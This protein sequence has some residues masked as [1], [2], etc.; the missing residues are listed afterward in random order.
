MAI[1]KIHGFERDQSTFS[2]QGVQLKVS[3]TILI[4]ATTPLITMAEVINALPNTISGPGGTTFN[5]LQLTFT[6]FQSRHP[7]S[8]LYYLENVQSLK[9]TGDKGHFWHLRLSYSTPAA[10]GSPGSSGSSSATRSKK[11]QRVKKPDSPNKDLQEPITDPTQRPAVFSGST[12][13]LTQ[14]RYLNLD[15]EV[16][17]HTNHM[18]ITKPIPFEIL[19]ESWTWAWNIGILSTHD[20]FHNRSLGM[21]SATNSDN[22]TIK[23]DKNKS[24][25]I[26]K[27]EMKCMGMSYAEEWETPSS[28]EEFHY[29][30]VTANFLLTEGTIWG[31]APIS[32]H[33]LQIG[34]DG[35]SPVPIEINDRKQHAKVPWPL[36]KDGT[37][38]PHGEIAAGT[39]NPD[40]FGR[41][42]AEGEDLVTVRRTAFGPFFSYYNLTLPIYDA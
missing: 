15:D 25:S 7:S 13:T 14:H 29:V 18:P 41:L 20:F 21:I 6:L 40:D 31:T 11:N 10:S 24:I 30:R 35:I 22:F 32:Q 36:K 9:R 34:S 19:T 23:V 37:A 28:G 2:S 38:V 5:P 33:T 16:I 27:G 39:F 8:D 1:Q 26:K 42:Q 3:E 12:Q 4:E 17:R